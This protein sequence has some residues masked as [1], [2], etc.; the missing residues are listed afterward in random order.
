METIIQEWAAD[1]GRVFLL[2]GIL[3][4]VIRFR[5]MPRAIHPIG[6][7][8]VLNLI[9]QQYAIYLW[10]NHENNLWLLHVNTWLE[11]ILFSLFFR[12][13]YQGFSLFKRYFWGWIGVG[14]LGLVATS[15]WIEPFT[16]FNTIAKSVV[17]VSLLTY[18]IMYFIDSFGKLDFS[19]RRHQA[20]SMICFAILLY[21]AGSFFIFL[22][23]TASVSTT[24]A[25]PYDLIWMINSLM[26]AL[27][28][29]IILIAL[30]LMAIPKKLDRDHY[31]SSTP[32]IIW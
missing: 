22:F 32:M 17:Q 21:Y 30:L 19:R 4:W 16:G 14:L 25:Q 23:A 15:I 31:V 28:Q 18:V 26:V 12:E 20:I 11:F 5:K 7:Y 3:I 1:I 27:F 24:L 2:I 8:F 10:G 13:I 6:V 29:L 9:I